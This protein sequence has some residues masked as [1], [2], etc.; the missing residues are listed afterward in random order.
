MKRTFRVV[1]VAVAV[2]LLAAPAQPMSAQN[3]NVWN[4]QYFNNPSWTQPYYVGTT[5]SFIDFNWGT[6]PPAPGMPAS[7]NWTATMT[8]SVNFNQA[9]YISPGAGRRRDLAAD[10]RRDLPEHHWCG[11]VGQ[12]GAGGGAAHGRVPQP[13]RAIPP[14]QRRGLRLSQLGVLQAGCRLRLHAAA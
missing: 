5:S 2:L 3:G 9:T 12:D 1:V 6:V 10:R 11:H 7:T 4:I 14:V 8:S 13:R